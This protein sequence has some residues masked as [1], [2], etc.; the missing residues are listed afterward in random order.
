MQCSRSS[1]VIN[2]YAR[3]TWIKAAKLAAK[4]GDQG[5]HF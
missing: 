2:L 1:T 5:G 3:V 4:G